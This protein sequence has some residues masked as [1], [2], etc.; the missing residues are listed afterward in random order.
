M[1]GNIRST[2]RKTVLTTTE[3]ARLLGVSQ[4][5][6]HNW[7]EQKKMPS[8]KTSG[9]QYRIPKNVVDVIFQQRKA[10]LDESDV[11][12]SISLLVVEDDSVMLTFYD[13][14]FQTWGLPINIVTAVN[15]FD[16]LIQ[17]GKNIPN[18]IITDLLM[19]NMD[20]IEMVRALR[21]KP[22][23]DDTIIVVV[24]VLKPDEIALRGG[25]PEDIP[26]FQKPAPADRLHTIIRN[27]A[28]ALGLLGAKR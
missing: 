22:E 1:G 28:L 12:T 14:M 21:E 26:V 15:G 27:K 17:V 9:G 23:L 20:G 6:V 24:T 8:W 19:P 2:D 18:I 10:A 13:S 3:A 7:V 25:L 16:A 5:T 11:S 4:R